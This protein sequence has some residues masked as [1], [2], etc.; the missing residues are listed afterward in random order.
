MNEG[1]VVSRSS[2]ATALSEFNRNFPRPK[3]GSVVLSDAFRI[4][5]DYAG[6]SFPNSACGG[7]YLIFD[8]YDN[9]L[10]VGKADGLGV[11]LGAHFGWNA[12]RTAGRVKSAKLKDAYAVRTIGLPDESRFESTAIEAFL[13]RKLDPSLNVVGRDPL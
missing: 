12:E 11:R 9:L 2:V 1:K 5:E 3:V 13:I 8:R 6:G 7:V 4:V 10:Y